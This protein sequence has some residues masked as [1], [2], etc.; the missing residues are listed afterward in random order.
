MPITGSVDVENRAIVEAADLI[1]ASARTAPK[2][3]GVDNISTAVV[4]GGEKNMLADAMEHHVQHKRNPLPFFKRDAEAVRKSPAVILIGVKG[5]MPKKHENPLD[6]GA[7]GN[8]TC[9]D[10]ITT[11]KRKGED[12][13]GPICIFE[14]IDLGIALGSAVKMASELNID[15]RLMYTIGVA[16]MDLELLDADV[17][18]GIPVSLTG[19][20]IY[21]DRP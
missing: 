6:C 7:C 2:G 19:K 9:A 20:N 18:V 11:E 13:V 5:T 16:A 21:F 8:E 15:N 12:F 17:I 14:A 10:F 4:T 1:A 3:R